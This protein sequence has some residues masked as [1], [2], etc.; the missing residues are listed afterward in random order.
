MYDDNIFRY[1]GTILG[2]Y[3]SEVNMH[4]SGRPPSR[5]AMAHGIH[6]PSPTGT[7][8]SVHGK[9]FT[10]TCEGKRDDSGGEETRY[11]WPEDTNLIQGV[12]DPIHA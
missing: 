7:T 1:F 5:L 2:R 11:S 9:G 10:T 8:D 6:T 4:S 3:A 12:E